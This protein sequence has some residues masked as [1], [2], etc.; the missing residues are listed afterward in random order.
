MKKLIYLTLLFSLLIINGCKK[1]QSI[2]MKPLGDNKDLSIVDNTKTSL[3]SST[4]NLELQPFSDLTP[5][6]IQNLDEFQAI[7][8][9]QPTV[10]SGT[11]LYNDL[12]NQVIG[13]QEWNTLTYEEQTYI[14]NFTPQ[15]KAMLA[16]ILEAANNSAAAGGSS[17][18][19]HCA[20]SALGFNQAYTLFA[21]AFTTGMT[22][23][24]ALQ[25]LKFVG[26]KYLGYIALAVAIYEF[27]E[28]VSSDIETPRQLVAKQLDSYLLPVPVSITQQYCTTPEAV[29]DTV[30]DLWLTTSVYYNSIDNKYYVDSSN[31]TFVPNGYYL[32]NQPNLGG[33]IIYKVIDGVSIAAY[34]IETL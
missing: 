6:D 21:S 17:K 19:V 2:D 34:T 32:T 31:S 16:I 23:T 9:L 24:T 25:A 15:Q 26:V 7:Q 3:K 8:L 30:N 13:T 28:C 12:M 33:Y 1:E 11:T 5:T 22:A 20:L 18:W 14:L 10:E 27:V 4:L 29:L